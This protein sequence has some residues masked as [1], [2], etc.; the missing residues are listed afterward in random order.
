VSFSI[1][2]IDIVGVITNYQYERPSWADMFFARKPMY[3]M[4]M[5]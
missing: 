5:L 4:I 3:I 2:G 1:Q